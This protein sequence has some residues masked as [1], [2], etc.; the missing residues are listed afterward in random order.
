MK[1]VLYYYYHLNINELH[2]SKKNYFFIVDQYSYL[3]MPYTRPLEEANALYLL[4]LELAKSNSYYH[5]I[6]LN[7]EQQM[8]TFVGTTP[9]VLL[10]ITVGQNKKI[11]WKDLLHIHP[12]FSNQL[13]SLQVLTR[14]DWTSLWKQKIDYFEYQIMHF[15]NKYPLLQE[16]IFYFIGL[17]ENAISY[18]ENTLQEEKKKTP[19]FDVVSHKRVS[20]TSELFDFYNPL[21]V[22]IDYRVR[23][24]AEY[25]KSC[26]YHDLDPIME[27]SKVL[28]QAQLDAF[29]SRLLYGRL[30]Y[31]SFYFDCYDEIINGQVPM[32]EILKITSKID[33]YEHFLYDAYELLHAYFEIPPIP[34]LIKKF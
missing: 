31:P 30:L 3:F 1:N 11:T 33:D 14:Y 10:Q 15:Q 4:N 18:I 17:G 20:P 27:L 26:F 23:D 28:E 8:I 32:E 7:K 29:D 5:R 21:N 9:Y 34:W 24:L 2:Q 16:T 12:I 19:L 13:K 6:I 25:L 22:V